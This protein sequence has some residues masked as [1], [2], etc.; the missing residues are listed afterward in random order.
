MHNCTLENNFNLMILITSSIMFNITMKIINQE[1]RLHVTCK[2]ESDL[3]KAYNF[4]VFIF[5]K[6]TSAV[7]TIEVNYFNNVFKCLSNYD[8]VR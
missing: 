1:K 2:L 6:V 5:F 3:Q 8:N 4:T 7:L